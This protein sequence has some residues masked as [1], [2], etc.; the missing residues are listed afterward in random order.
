MCAILG[1]SFAP[2]SKINRKK[3]T[4]ALLSE[5]KVRGRD[6]SGYAWVSPTANGMFKKNVPGDQLYVGHIPEDATAIIAHTRAATHGKSSDNDNNHPIESPGGF[7]RLVHNGVI[8]NHDEVRG[9]FDKKTQKALP[10]V[11]SSVIGAVIEEFGLDQTNIIEGDAACAWFDA[12]TGDTIHL[13]RFQNSTVSFAMLRDGS[14]V[15]ASTGAILAA[16]LKKINQSWFGNWP[17]PFDS[18]NE[19]EYYQIIAGE[20]ISNSDVEWGDQYS[21]R[22][23][24]NSKW[25]EVTSGATTTPTT[26]TTYTAGSQQPVTATNGASFGKAAIEQKAIESKKEEPKKEEKTASNPTLALITNDKPMALDSGNGKLTKTEKYVAQALLNKKGSED[27]SFTDQHPDNDDPD[28]EDDLG[29]ESIAP[30][31]DLFFTWG[32]DGDYVTYTTLSGLLASLSWNSGVT[33]GE[34]YLVGPDEGKLR[35]VNT[36]ADIGHLSPDETDELSWVKTPGAWEVY[37]SQVPSWV[38]EGIGKLRNLVGA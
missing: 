33:V 14:F 16:A 25:R 29:D 15:F 27:S 26:G 24:Y 9:Y 8:W 31:R 22:S 1:I 35:W 6:A 32:H 11:D 38:G 2:G 18:M 21:T 17:T 12:E 34:N 10:D 20:V 23:A 30:F 36:F 19:S 3:V 7:I 13:A 28:Y 4:N 5:G 37:R